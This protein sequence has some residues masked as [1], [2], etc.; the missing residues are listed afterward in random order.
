MLLITL[1]NEFNHYIRRVECIGEDVTKCLTDR[2]NIKE[3][4]EGGEDMLTFI[5]GVEFFNEWSYKQ[6]IEIYNPDNWN[7]SGHFKNLYTKHTTSG[8]LSCLK[9]TE[10]RGHCV[11][12]Y[13][14]ED[15]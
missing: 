7:T 4:V 1:I 15:E 5:F 12:G 14:D 13:K 10:K 2:R 11:E 3:K 6:A 8:V 9:I